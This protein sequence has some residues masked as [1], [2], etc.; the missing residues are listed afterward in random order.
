[1]GVLF[2]GYTFAA[3]NL[4]AGSD[5]SQAAPAAL[6]AG[7]QGAFNAAAFAVMAAVAIAILAFLIDRRQRKT[8]LQRK[9]D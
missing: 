1:M 6:L 8:A 5:F 2:S 4:P 9:L 7:T 3:A